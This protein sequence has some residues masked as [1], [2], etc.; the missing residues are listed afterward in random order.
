MS[1]NVKARADV[2]LLPKAIAASAK[3]VDCALDAF[4]P[5]PDGPQARVQEAMSDTCK[6]RVRVY[7]TEA[8]DPVLRINETVAILVEE[9]KHCVRIVLCSATHH[10]IRRQ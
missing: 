9:G 2:G 6:F 3:L 1:D 7:A 5:R 4:L 8:V 10:T